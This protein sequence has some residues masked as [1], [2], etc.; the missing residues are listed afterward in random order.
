LSRVIEFESRDAL[1]AEKH[2]GL[3]QVV[4]LLSVD[5]AFQDVLLDVKIVVANGREPVAELGE[6][7]DGL[8]D[9]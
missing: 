7:F 5:K 8:F 1:T 3:C 9:P 4:E 6:V 2:R